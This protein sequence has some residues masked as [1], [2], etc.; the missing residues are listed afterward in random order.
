MTTKIVSGILRPMDI[1][2]RETRSQFND[3]LHASD[4]ALYIGLQKILFASE[5]ERN[6]YS[7]HLR[8]DGPRM[9]V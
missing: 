8:L 1:R 4:L 5:K 6:G 7:E 2:S 9:Y 3:S